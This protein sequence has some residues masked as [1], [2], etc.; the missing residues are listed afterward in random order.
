MIIGK[1]KTKFIE[2]Q[3]ELEKYKNINRDLSNTIHTLKETA[4]NGLEKYV[5]FNYAKILATSSYIKIYPF[6]RKV[7]GSF[8]FEV[9]INTDK[10]RYC[11]VLFTDAID[12]IN[13]YDNTKRNALFEL[14]KDTCKFAKNMFVL[15]K[16]RNIS[17]CEI[18]IID[19]EIS[20][21][22]IQYFLI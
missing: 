20:S 8:L 15:Y 4:D 5:N 12:K 13:I 6:V 19:N 10:D 11:E 17:K 22:I 18:E 7:N 1:D 14:L 9:H 16:K 2:M 3:E 21:D